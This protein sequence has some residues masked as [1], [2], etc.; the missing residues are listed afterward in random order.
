M[1]H[2]RLCLIMACK[3]SQEGPK[4][5]VL[6]EVLDY[7]ASSR[8]GM[9][10]WTNDDGVVGWT[11]WAPGPPKPISSEPRLRGH[12]VRHLEEAGYFRKQR[13]A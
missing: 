4:C 6:Y 1:L 3:W 12:T 13:D 8:I 7:K 2:R 5:W 9:V 11:A 10:I